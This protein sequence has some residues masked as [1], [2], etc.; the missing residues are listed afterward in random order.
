KSSR[1]PAP[2]RLSD[3]TGRDSR[4]A[5]LKAARFFTTTNWEGDDMAKDWLVTLSAAREAL[6]DADRPFVKMLS[7]GTTKVELYAPAD[8]DAQ[9][10]HDQDEI[11]V[12]V[13]GTGMFNKAGERKPFGPHD[14]IFVEAG[15]EHRFEGFSDDF[16]TWVIF[17]GPKSG[18]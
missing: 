2:P 15:V 7:S 9:T 6:F 3:E 18:D 16:Q 5:F 12:I 11:Y 10:P 17:F 8:Y 13:S 14:V 1:S 4:A